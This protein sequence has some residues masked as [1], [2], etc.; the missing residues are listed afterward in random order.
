M[1]REIYINRKGKISR[2]HNWL[3]FQDR[4]RGFMQGLGKGKIDCLADH[5]MKEYLKI[6]RN[7]YKSEQ[8]GKP[9]RIP[10][11]IR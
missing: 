11:A 1:G 10:K 6:I 9:V 7:L 3:R 4:L 5:S 2:I 8:E